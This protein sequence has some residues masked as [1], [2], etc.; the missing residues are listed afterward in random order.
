MTV[1]QQLEKVKR[2]LKK[3]KLELAKLQK[4]RNIT[5]KKITRLMK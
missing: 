4:E 5:R 3:K 2:D 1:K